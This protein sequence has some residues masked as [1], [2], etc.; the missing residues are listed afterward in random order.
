MGWTHCHAD[1]R[2]SFRVPDTLSHSSAC[3]IPL[4]ANTAWL[5]LF[6]QGCLA[7]ARETTAIRPPILI[8]GG[9]STV[10]YFAIQM[11]RL[12]GHEVIT[13]CSPRNFELARRAGATHVFDY[14]EPEVTAKIRSAAPDLAHVF[15]TIGWATSSATACKAMDGRPGVLCTVRPGK[16]H[17]GDV[18]PNVKVTDVFVFTAFPKPHSYRG[19]VHWAVT[20]INMTDHELSVELYDQLPALLADGKLVPPTV[21]V[22]GALSP[23]T[24]AEAMN[25][26][27]SGKI[28]GEKLCFRVSA[29]A[30]AEPEGAK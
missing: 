8:W 16:A 1:E 18:P 6:S 28:S 21:K 22:V 29:D 24:V 5:A 25:L 13:T 19:V 10:G 3:S 15:D 27:R 26:N 12:H 20:Q 11:A 17:T 14:N 23:E 4:A 30:A 7:L 2:I 9:S